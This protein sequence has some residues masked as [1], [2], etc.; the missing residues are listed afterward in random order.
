LRH[1]FADPCEG[2]RRRRERREGRSLPHDLPATPQ[3]LL[4]CAGV[5]LRLPAA[6]HQPR[7]A[8]PR[9]PLTDAVRGNESQ[10]SAPPRPFR[11]TWAVPP[12]DSAIV[13]TIE[14]PR[15]LP[16]PPRAASG[17]AKRSNASGRNAFGRPSPLSLT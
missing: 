1:D 11:A 10:A 15:P 3:G 9:D 2:E 14:R 4:L 6:H 12:C 16:P 5:L 17:R 8:L 7:P 13:F